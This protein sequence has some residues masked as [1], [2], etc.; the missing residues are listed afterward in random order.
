SMTRRTS[1]A[2]TRLSIPSRRSIA[3]LYS[4]RATAT[5]RANPP[6]C[7]NMQSSVPTWPLAPR[8]ATRGAPSALA[9]IHLLDQLRGQE[10]GAGVDEIGT[11]LVQCFEEHSP[12][13]CDQR[14]RFVRPEARWRR[15][16]QIE[17]M[18]R[19]H[20]DLVTCPD[21]EGDR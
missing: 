7:R 12:V 18:L 11:P 10:R 20:D 19:A 8:I 5:G 3:R 2:A 9:L 6:R 13:L 1:S 14:K 17:A 15:E 4:E 21:I 16:R